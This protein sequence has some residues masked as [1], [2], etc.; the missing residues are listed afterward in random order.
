MTI[1]QL[2]AALKKNLADA[3]NASKQV[4]AWRHEYRQHMYRR[5]QLQKD[6]YR[7]E[8]LRKLNRLNAATVGVSKKSD[9]AVLKTRPVLQICRPVPCKKGSNITIIFRQW[10]FAVPIDAKIA[11]IFLRARLITHHDFMELIS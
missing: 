9:W 4:R 8:L 11:E 6:L 10:H 2:R 5:K 7:L 1:T 3:R